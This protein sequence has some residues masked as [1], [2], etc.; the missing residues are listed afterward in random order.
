LAAFTR[1]D[2][3]KLIDTVSGEQHSLWS[4]TGASVGSLRFTPEG[5]WL[6]AGCSDRTVRLW[7]VANGRPILVLG[8]DHT[9]SGT[10][11]LPMRRQLITTDGSIK[12]WNVEISRFEEETTN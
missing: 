11:W 5:R 6:M 1:A 9:A 10:A 7:S 4:S 12:V 3:L 8:T 2:G